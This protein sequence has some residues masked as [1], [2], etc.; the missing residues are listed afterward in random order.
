M[1]ITVKVLSLNKFWRYL[2]NGKMDITVKVLSLSKFWRY[3]VIV[4]IRHLNSQISYI[5]RKKKN[6]FCKKIH[7]N[8]VVHILNFQL[9][10]KSF[11][12][13]CDFFLHFYGI[14]Y[15]WDTQYHRP[16]MLPVPLLGSA[17]VW[18]SIKLRCQTGNKHK[19]V[20]S[21][22]DT[23]YGAVNDEGLYFK[24]KYKRQRRR[25][26]RQIIRLSNSTVGH[27]GLIQV[28]GK[29]VVRHKERFIRDFVFQ[30]DP[31]IKDWCT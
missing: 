14:T 17:I 28:I 30:W 12:V 20:W 19:G 8:V 21:F 23:L 10:A 5:N 11:S 29:R 7:C 18:H 4:K 9:S 13:L 16:F 6:V 1:D 31:D 26:T 22:F 27:S 3:L 15:F 25:K 2:V 24:Q